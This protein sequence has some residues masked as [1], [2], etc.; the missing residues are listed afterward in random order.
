MT[1]AIIAR[2]KGDEYQARIFWIHLLKLRTSDYIET[3]YLESDKV[4][5]LDD[6]VVNYKLPICERSTGNR[7]DS[8]LF[9]CKYH[10]AQNGAFTYENLLDPGF[11]NCKSESM[12]RRLYSAYIKLIKENKSFRLY[13]VSNWFWH[14]D[15][16]ISKHLSEERIRYTFFEGGH[17]SKIGMIRNEFRDHLGIT[18]NELKCFLETIRFQLGKNLVDLAREMEPL[19]KLANLK[20]ID[21]SATN[22]IYD[23]LAWKLFEQGRNK[24]NRDALDQMLNDEKLIIEN[25]PDYSE[26]SVCSC[27]QGARRPR[28]V[29]A[30]HLDLTDLFNGHFPYSDTYWAKEIPQRIISFLQKESVKNLPNPIHLFFD[31]HLS[32]AFLC[33]YL[34][35][36]KYG[37]KIIPAQKINT[38]GYEFWPEPR[39]SKNNLWNIEIINELKNKG[40][41]AISVSN[42]ITSHLIEY[43]KLKKMENLLIISIE[44]ISGIGP[45]A[46]RDGEHAWQLGFELQTYLRRVLPQQFE[47]LHIFY[48]GPVA[49]AYI[50]GNTL[51]HVVKHI[52]LYEHDFEGYCYE[53]RYYPS[54]KLPIN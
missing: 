52:Q 54:I 16:E 37:I 1:K 11:I 46:I 51:R 50:L 21:L 6:V 13:I 14:P 33:G 48:S 22:I 38:L 26:I 23:D 35:N 5:F 2:R 8:D 28:D 17:K 39:N 49:L 27:P 20:P 43:L 34:V 31:C 30:G 4:S 18:E 40:I 32:I 45:K 7:I 44:P 53:Y 12:L 19:L 25:P 29:Q 15:D 9:Q 36:P 3:V 41:L 24:F 10:V 42:P 47:K